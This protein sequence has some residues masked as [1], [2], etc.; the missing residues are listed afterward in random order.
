MKLKFLALAAF[1]F[2]AFSTQAQID[3]S[4][5]PI[6]G[7]AP[8]I[9]L[10]TPST[11]TLKNGLKVMVVE[12]H[13]L[14]K[15]NYSLRIDNG[16]IY[17]GD[18]AGISQILAA[19]LGNGTSTI[20][21][22]DFNEEVDF[23]GANL[24]FGSASASGSS[25]T[26]YSNRIL[27]LMA[28]AAMN[29]LLT[30]EEFQKEKEKAIENLK[31]NKKSVDAVAS[32]VSR[33]LSYGKNHPSGE[34]VTEE[35]LNNITLNNVISYYHTHFNPS[36]AYLVVLGDVNVSKVKK[37]VKKYFGKWEHDLDISTP[38][39]ESTPNVP[40][41]EIDFIDMPNAVQS[42]IQFTNN[43]NL[44]MKDEDYHAVLLANYI[45]GGGGEGY[46][47]LN[48]REDKGYTYGSYS[49]IGTKRFVPG[50]FSATASVRNEVTD[51]SV[52]AMLGEIKRIRTEKVDAER[53]KNAKA[54]YVGSF[55]LAVERPSTVA[56]Y[57]L[58]IELNNLPQDFYKTYLSKI[59]AVTAD[60]ILRVANKYFL[61][62]N[63][64][65]VIVGKG[66]EVVPNLEK[67]GFPIK[68]YDAYANPVEKP[69]FSK[70]IPNGVTVS[71]VLDQFFKASGGK[72]KMEAVKSLNMNANV[73]IDG[74]PI[75][76]TAN[77]KTMVP[78]K[79]SMEMSAGAMGVLMSQ[80]WN[81]KQG[82]QTQQ[83]QRKEL[84][85]AEIAEKKSSRSIFPELDYTKE[86]AA[87]ESIVSVEGNDNYLMKVTKNDKT[88]SRYYDVVTGL[89]TKT[90][91]SSEVQGKKII[92]TVMYSNY[93][94]VDGLQLPFV[95]IIKAGP[96]N[97][98]INMTTI[99]VNEGVKDA[100]FD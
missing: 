81:G 45:L 75:P 19:M 87:L 67:T 88:E 11:F 43:V 72:D 90:E 24:N 51:S 17:D 93:Q 21:K 85:D 71:A 99:Q 10:K 79:E 83:G 15:V 29:P 25:L 78:N 49:S 64:R 34:F 33:A 36:K 62:D 97:L 58:N 35:T 40:V 61:A 77:L 80:K 14:P 31:S 52:V 65:F 73:K 89:L 59:N 5:Q 69:V 23:L 47:F 38:I 96:Q 56:G 28:D 44:E 95:N 37:Q 54:K 82:Y 63:G 46:L 98:V 42:N 50:R 53:L 13:K 8:T 57:A 16:P 70:A 7:P 84:T 32:R 9:S 48:L 12:N 92:N 41:T 66:S 60:D 20:S 55:V 94:E 91:S 76:L 74:V 6:P 30:E 22:N 1:C 86:N 68:Y 18:K 4:K 100:D 2:V 27:E 39:I 26:K 3:R